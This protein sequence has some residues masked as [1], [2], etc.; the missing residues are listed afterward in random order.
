[1][2]E[3]GMEGVEE[4]PSAA[5]QAEEPDLVDAVLERLEELFTR[6]TLI[7]DAFIQQHMNAQLEISLC[8]L[9]GHPRI[10][11]LGKS[12]GVA[13]LLEAAGR[14]DKV[15]LDE[16][17]LLMRPNIKPRRNTLILRD[18]A[19]GVSEE[20]IRQLFEGSSEG[21]GLV[22]VKP[23]VN[24]TAFVV[25]DTDDDA[26]RAALWLRSQTLRGEGV[27]CNI[28][29]ER[30][31]SSF[32]APSQPPPVAVSVKDAVYAMSGHQAQMMMGYPGMWAQP[33]ATMD[34]MSWAGEDV[35][36]A[37]W[38]EARGAGDVPQGWFPDG[39]E[40]GKKGFKGKGKGKYKD[41]GKGKD[42]D[43]GK[44]AGS[45]GGLEQ[46]VMQMGQA[47]GMPPMQEEDDLGGRPPEDD[48]G[49]CLG[50][51]NGFR[52]YGRAEIIEICSG[53][54][55][56]AKPGGFTRLEAE[57]PSTALLFLESPCKDWAPP[58]APQPHLHDR[59]GSDDF[60]FDGGADGGW[61]SY[62]RGKGGRKGGKKGVWPEQEHAEYEQGDWDESA[63]WDGWWDGWWPEEQAG[64]RG[65]RSSKSGGKG[66]Q[67]RRGSEDEWYG[68]EPQQKWMPKNRGGEEVGEEAPAESWPAEGRG[69]RGSWV[70]KARGGS[71]K[72]QA[73]GKEEPGGAGAEEQGTSAPA[74]AGSEPGG[75]DGGGG[76]GP[77]PACDGSSK[78]TG[79]S[80]ADKVR[81]GSPKIAAAPA[82]TD[83]A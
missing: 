7:K 58:P 20:D 78:S 71:Q 2:P 66:K 6:E 10:A 30:L 72:W 81:Q 24:H 51:P 47:G 35:H 74:A 50:Y 60:G 9:P 40:G 77:S 37:G 69:Q 80:W 53:M 15:I 79:M 55:E 4:Q 54:D 39:A 11:T 57:D 19:D 70:E 76:G 65:S 38:Q 43:K 17:K 12:V 75:A 44:F 28:K 25:F 1:M 14:C 42:K 41:K 46:P 5:L 59:R 32:F 68:G 67:W 13:C 56:V 73:K 49:D 63:E 29:S 83:P 33:G 27:K 64:R 8:V 45:F 23:D 34:Q 36:E 82:P 26:Q 31:Q 52:R 48:F 21:E 18:L 61:G 3:E 16:E 62:G 22:S